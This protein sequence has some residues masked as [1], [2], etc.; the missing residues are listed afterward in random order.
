MSITFKRG[1][2]RLG[3]ALS[4]LSLP[5]VAV[6]AYENSSH[7]AGFE[8]SRVEYLLAGNVPRDVRPVQVQGLGIVYA[9]LSMSESQIDEY[10]KRF[11]TRATNP[12][13][14]QVAPGSITL[15]DFAERVRAKHPGRY[16]SSD[17]VKL[18]GAVLAE[19]P[20]YRDS[21]SVREFA[22]QPRHEKRI[23]WASG[24]TVLIMAAVTLVI[25][26][27]ISVVAWIFRGFRP[28]V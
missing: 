2:R 9:P 4:A 24:V 7:V 15:E 19:F 8:P 20:E 6:I 21:L 28:V 22:L 14:F 27:G 25:Q 3:W 18:V 11:F 23:G 16:S 5:F 1:F 10:V 17:D 13:V 12:V 26:G